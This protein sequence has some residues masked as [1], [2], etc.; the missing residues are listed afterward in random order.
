MIFIHL[1][2]NNQFIDEIRKVVKEDGQYKWSVACLTEIQK[3]QY[4]I[5]K[6]AVS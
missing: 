5:G 4:E 3:S 1:K 6:K 2:T